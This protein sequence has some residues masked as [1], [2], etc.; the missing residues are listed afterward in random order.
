MGMYVYLNSRNGFRNGK[1][2]N[3]V[4]NLYFMGIGCWF[5]VNWYIIWTSPAL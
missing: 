1:N 3:S 4:F 5:L 2:I